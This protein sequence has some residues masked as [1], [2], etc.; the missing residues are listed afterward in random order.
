MASAQKPLVKLAYKEVGL[1][2]VEYESS[3]G[4]AQNHPI[5]LRSDPTNDDRGGDE[6]SKLR[7][8]YNELR[9]RCHVDP[10]RLTLVGVGDDESDEFYCDACEQRRDPTHWVYYCKECEFSAH[11]NCV[12]S[13]LL[14]GIRLPGLLQFDHHEH[15]ISLITKVPPQSS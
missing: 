7:V 6:M 3:N 15:L 12:V 11:M 1:P 13:E 5:E 14:G 8:Q 9:H 4:I 2:S 10:L